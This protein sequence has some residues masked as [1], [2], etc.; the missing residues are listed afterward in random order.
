MYSQTHVIS[1][2]ILPIWGS[3]G[4]RWF[5][6]NVAVPPQSQLTHPP[7]SKWPPFCRRYFKM[8][9]PEWKDLQFDYNFTEACSWGLGSQLKSIGAKPLSEQMLPDSL[10]HTCGTRGGWVKNF[11]VIRDH[12]VYACSQ[13]ETTLDLNVVSH[14][15]G[16]YTKWSLCN[17][18]PFAIK[19]YDMQDR[20]TTTP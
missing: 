20:Y 9:F 18:S 7:W 2:D 4:Y 10:P 19:H 8:H 13:W 15:L 1:N 3:K 5:K 17:V 14:W 11:G 12:F 6:S 16:A